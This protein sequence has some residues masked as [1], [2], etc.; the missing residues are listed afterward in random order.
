M[1]SFV[2]AV[3]QSELLGIGM[4][5]VFCIQSKQMRVRR[6]QSIEEQPFKAPMKINFLMGL[7]IFP[8]FLIILLIPA[9]IWL[10]GSLKFFQ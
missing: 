10:M 1:T 2:A 3:I 5:K 6:C 4:A 9:G 8:V 7:I